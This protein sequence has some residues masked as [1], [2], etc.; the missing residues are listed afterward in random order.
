MVL[1]FCDIDW[2]E[3][4]QRLSRWAT[5]QSSPAPS[6]TLFHAFRDLQTLESTN[7][8]WDEWGEDDDAPENEDAEQHEQGYYRIDFFSAL[9]ERKVNL[10]SRFFYL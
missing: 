5:A 7:M 6:T 2:A 9:S 1:D 8:M 3:G 10:C 4:P